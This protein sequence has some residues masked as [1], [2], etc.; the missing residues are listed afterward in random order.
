VKIYLYITIILFGL[1]LR[2]QTMEGEYFYD[3]DPGNGNGIA[4]SVTLVEDELS[5]ELDF[6]TAEL[7]E[8]LHVLGVRM[9]NNNVWGFPKLT[10]FIVQ[11]KNEVV[12][13]LISGEYYF[14]SDPGIGNGTPFQL[15]NPQSTV[16]EVIEFDPQTMANGL[17][18]VN[19]RINNSEDSWSFPKTVLFTVANTIS[20]GFDNHVVEAEYFVN[21][22]PGIGQATPITFTNP[23][24]SVDE[25][26]ELENIAMAT[27]L[28]VVFIR[29]KNSF[30]IWGF[31]KPVMY[32]N[33]PVE[34]KK[35]NPRIVALEYFIDVDPGVGNGAVVEIDSLTFLEGT[36]LIPFDPNLTWESHKVG[37]RV[38]DNYGQWGTTNGSGFEFCPTPPSGVDST[39]GNTVCHGSG[40][41]KLKAWKDGATQYRWWDAQ[42]DGNLLRTE[43]DN[44][45]NYTVS[46]SATYY[47]S[48]Y[49]SGYVC[50]NSSR[51]PVD[52]EVIP[53]L[54]PS[55]VT[56]SNVSICRLGAVQFEPIGAPADGGYLWYYSA[57]GGSPFYTADVLFTDTL[58]QPQQFMYVSTE[59][60]DGDC[61]YPN[62]RLKLTIVTHD[63]F[64]QQITF[65]PITPL[66]LGDPA[67]KLG[68]FS[69]VFD[70]NGA[71]SGTLPL[72]YKVVSGPGE[73][74]EGTDS[75]MFFNVGQIII[76][77]TQPG[78][79]TVNPADA[80]TAEILI[81]SSGTQLVASTNSPVC[82]REAL[83][84]NASSILN[85]SYNWEGPNGFVSSSRAFNIID[86]SVLDTG[87]YTVTAVT[88]TVTYRATVNVTVF[89]EAKRVFVSALES[90]DCL[91]KIVGLE[92]YG[93]EFAEY[94]WLLDGREIVDSDTADYKPLI[95]GVYSVEGLD[96]NGCGSHS[97]PV[98]IDLRPDSVPSISYFLNP[99][100]LKSSPAHS[101]QWYVNNFYVVGGD[102]QELPLFV[103]GSYKVK[104]TNAEGCV[105]YSKD[106][107]L[108]SETLGD[109]SRN[110]QVKGNSVL[111]GDGSMEY[112]TVTLQPNPTSDLL[113]ISYLSVFD[114]LPEVHIYDLIGT[115]VKSFTLDVAGF[116]YFEKTISV[117]GLATG[118]YI[119]R[120]KG[121]NSLITYKFSVQ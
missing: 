42:S 19:F 58:T 121:T 1:H 10:P 2:A 69:N 76:E 81:I 53:S 78:N 96:E 116:D 15:N 47:V 54:A 87:L 113:T 90:D 13:Q 11:K 86:V 82:E 29:V 65:N 95:T 40:D 119:L 102:Q 48:V 72:V 9:K 79:D 46:E 103:R 84:F 21:T 31:A 18:S 75:L 50:K 118:V 109:F 74:I 106:I 14:D 45:F 55:S 115:E 32:Q 43:S 51:V 25:V 94:A 66:I 93:A 39:K 3:A 27:G 99:D 57:T 73:I 114:E 88:T 110:A 6:V 41:A 33:I 108:L 35:V 36:Y 22:D 44:T 64:S 98:F 112:E 23:S 60:R 97:A 100:R 80:V 34:A 117:K 104:T 92:A 71:L 101:Y 107:K 67:L 26:L 7:V 38:K 62:A 16:D 20:Q 5:S 56:N 120:L 17:H 4:F 28:N 68:G 12:D 63:C 83:Q 70:N 8:G 24:E 49:N 37:V 61:E 89:T 59:S 30:N 85:A 77:A 105:F 91:A 111:I 52:V